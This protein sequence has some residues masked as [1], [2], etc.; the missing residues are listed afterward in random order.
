MTG[1]VKHSYSMNDTPLKPWVAVW[2]SGRVECGHCTCMAG[3]AESCS[4]IAALLY[5]LETAVRINNETTCTSKPN[6]WIIPS[7]PT[8]CQY[9]PSATL[10]ELEEIAYSRQKSEG[11]EYSKLANQTPTKEELDGLYSHLE[12]AS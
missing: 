4:H 5:W 11:D 3:L 7:L 2:K 8:P 1:K 6:D 10:E 12:R 9:V